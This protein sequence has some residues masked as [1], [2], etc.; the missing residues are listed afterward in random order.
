VASLVWDPGNGTSAATSDIAARKADIVLLALP[1]EPIKDVLDSAGGLAGKTVI[2]LT[3]PASR[4]AD[5]GFYQMTTKPSGAEIIQSWIPDAM[6]VKAFGT[7]ASNIIDNPNSAGGA[8]SI[9]IASDHRQAKEITA[10]LAAELRL[11]PV[12]GGPLRMARNIEAMMEL[13]MV[14]HLQGRDAGWEFYFRRSNVEGGLTE[15]DK[16]NLAEIPETQP[17]LAPCAVDD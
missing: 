6:V 3:W 12:D 14:P 11:D 9:P 2:D 13:Y 7:A 15:G 8:V 16:A 10:R 1:W 17:P 5:D 4:E